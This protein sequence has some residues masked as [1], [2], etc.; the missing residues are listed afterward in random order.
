[1]Q[2]KQV[3]GKPFSLRYKSEE[4]WIEFVVQQS[5]NLTKMISLSLGPCNLIMMS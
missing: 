1:M 2:T 5:T 3:R 4:L